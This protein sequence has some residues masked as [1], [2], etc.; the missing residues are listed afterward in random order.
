L[1]WCVVYVVYMYVYMH[2]H[3]E[4]E[5]FNRFMPWVPLIFFNNSTSWSERRIENGVCTSHTT[6][7]ISTT[8]TTRT[9][10]TEKI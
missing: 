3:M 10:R 5:Y 9:T 8:T 6:Q 4:M 1:E 7:I 2:I